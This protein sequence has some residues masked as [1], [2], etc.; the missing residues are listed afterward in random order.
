MHHSALIGDAIL[1][2]QQN[3]QPHLS[4][5]FFQ[6]PD[7]IKEPL[8]VVTTVFNSQ[9]FRSRWRLYED[10]A[11]MVHESGAILYTVEVAFGERD[12]AVTQ[13]GNPRHIQLRTNHEVW[14]KEN[15]INVGVSRLPLDWRY[16]AWVDADCRFVRDD[17]ANETIHQLQ[18]FELVQMWSQFQDMNSNH[19]IIGCASSFMQ[20]YL[21]SWHGW[22]NEPKKKDVGCYYDFPEPGNAGLAI[23]KYPGAPGL[24]WAM[25]RESWDKVGGLLDVCC[26]GSGDWYMA[27][28]AI[29][30]LEDG[31]IRSDYHPSYTAAIHEWQRRAKSLHRNVGVVPGLALHHWHG[32]KV[33]RRYRTRDQILVENQFNPAT[34]LRKDWQGI[35]QLDVHD[36][37][38]MK[39]RD[40]LRGYFRQRN[41][42][43]L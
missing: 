40:D 34:D 18:H 36:D 14:L 4:P 26:L 41:E 2:A 30:A 37:R 6:R 28:A 12:F 11:K 1:Q 3:T 42:D 31:M 22:L 39:L 23:R 15:A 17:W 20:G 38:T 35:Y 8:Y 7:T 33:G 27:F 9:R 43:Q 21:Q 29:Q 10:F 25:R 13:P 19:E 32:H 16:V 24:A 5:T